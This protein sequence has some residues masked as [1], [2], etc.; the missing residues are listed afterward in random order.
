VYKLRRNEQIGAKDRNEKFELYLQEKVP[1][2]IIVDPQSRK[3]VVY[4]WKD[5]NYELVINDTSTTEFTLHDGCRFSINMENI[6]E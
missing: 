4:Q 5:G 3:T 1:Y 2:Y 6:W